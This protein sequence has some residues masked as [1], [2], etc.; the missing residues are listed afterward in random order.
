ML[1]WSPSLKPRR[2][3]EDDV[4]DREDVV[5]QKL[6]FSVGEGG[7]YTP[8]SLISAIA[9]RARSR[10][11]VLAAV[12]AVN[13]HS[14]L[15]L[16]S[17]GSLSLISLVLLPFFSPFSPTAAV[18]RTFSSCFRNGFR[19]IGMVE[20]IYMCVAVLSLLALCLRSYGCNCVMSRLLSCKTGLTE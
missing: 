7:R 11:V 17:T 5:P 1:N 2:G 19:M 15:S 8:E 14:P 16:Y 12:L 13:A 9:I 3:I 18:G 6:F 10:W 20:G 4:V